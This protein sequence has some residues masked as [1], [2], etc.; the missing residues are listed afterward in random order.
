MRERE[1][2][3]ESEREEIR[4]ACPIQPVESPS[5]FQGGYIHALKRE[6]RKDRKKSNQFFFFPSQRGFFEGM[7]PF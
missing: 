5:R 4:I 2:E 6:K 7:M 1:K 3:R